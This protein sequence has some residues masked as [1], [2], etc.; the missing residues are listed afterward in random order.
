MVGAR[1]DCFRI[2]VAGVVVDYV[3][4]L[5]DQVDELKRGTSWDGRDPVFAMESWVGSG[6]MPSA[7]RVWCQLLSNSLVFCSRT[8]D[9]AS[10]ERGSGL[11]KLLTGAGTAGE[12]VHLLCL[13]AFSSEEQRGYVRS[14]RVQVMPR[15]DV[16]AA[17]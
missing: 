9:D 10:D 12:D 1:C 7:A 3:Y 5:P 8:C 17:I 2:K 4:C 13:L 11:I 16:P 14:K 15:D 6:R